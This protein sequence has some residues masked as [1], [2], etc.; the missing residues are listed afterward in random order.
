MSALDPSIAET[1][2]E[3]FLKR[4]WPRLKASFARYRIPP[5]DTEDILQQAL[6]ALVYQGQSIRDP[7]A[8]LLGTVRN[9]C[10]LY[11]RDQRRKPYDAVDFSA[12][13]CM[14]EPTAPLQ[15]WADLH[16]DLANAIEQLP[17][18]C[19]SVLSLRYSEGYEA[20]EVAARLGYSPASISKISTRCLAALTRQLAASGLAKKKGGSRAP[21]QARKRRR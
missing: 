13:E 21:I 17:E 7:E 10:L 1:S 9:K 3:L 4:V 18:R 6:L 16:H 14:G 19:R 5:Q 12:L 20:T 15:E 8:W 2:L 11:W